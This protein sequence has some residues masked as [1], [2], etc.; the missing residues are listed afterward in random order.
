MRRECRNT[1]SV[2]CTVTSYAAPHF[3]RLLSPD[4]LQAIVATRCGKEPRVSTRAP[5]S[6]KAGGVGPSERVG[7]RACLSSVTSP[8][9]A[10]LAAS[11]QRRIKALGGFKFPGGWN[12]GFRSIQDILEG[13][14]CRSACDDPGTAGMGRQGVEALNH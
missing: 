11:S 8:H 4:L 6:E 14:R 12:G 3:F 9:A 13:E 2:A 7:C 1:V 5:P 10:S